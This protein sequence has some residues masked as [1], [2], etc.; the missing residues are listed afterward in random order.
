MSGVSQMSEQQSA[1]V[2]GFP[3]WNGRVIRSQRRVICSKMALI[4]DTSTKLWISRFW[5]RVFDRAFANF[6]SVEWLSEQNP[7]EINF[8]SVSETSW[9][10]YLRHDSWRIWIWRTRCVSLGK[11]KEF[12]PVKLTAWWESS[13]TVSL[14]KFACGMN[15]KPSS[16]IGKDGSFTRTSSEVRF[17]SSW[18]LSEN[19]DA[20]NWER[21]KFVS[22]EKSIWWHCAYKSTWGTARH[23]IKQCVAKRFATVVCKR[24][25]KPG[26]C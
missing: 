3:R 15:C 24:K 10:K 12:G 19:A 17:G 13:K 14:S 20:S 7:T 9:E 25:I 11:L 1:N 23:H 4:K 2:E 22:R 21:F 16:I 8:K 18:S 5:R 26:F 6:C